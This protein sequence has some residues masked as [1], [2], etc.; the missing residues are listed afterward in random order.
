MIWSVFPSSIP[1]SLFSTTIQQVFITA[2]MNE[3]VSDSESNDTD[4]GMV[5]GDDGLDAAMGNV[6]DDDDD[7]S[8]EADVEDKD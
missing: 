8:Y 4:G 5:N 3:F 1:S 7:G 6:G 2:N